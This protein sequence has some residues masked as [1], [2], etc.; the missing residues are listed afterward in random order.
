MREHEGLPRARD[1]ESQSCMIP[2]IGQTLVLFGGTLVIWAI[3]KKRREA[4]Q[5]SA[6]ATPN[7]F[8]IVLLCFLLNFV[9]LPYYFLRSRRSFFGLTLGIFFMVALLIASVGTHMALRFA[10]LG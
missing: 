5:T 2:L 8:V 4:S 7:A 10:H 6:D 1:W 9:C 3:D